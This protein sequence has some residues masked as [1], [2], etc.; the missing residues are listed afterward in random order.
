VSFE[1][2]YDILTALSKIAYVTD[3]EIDPHL[4]AKKIEPS[5][6]GFSINFE[7]VSFSYP[8]QQLLIFD[9]LSFEI[10][11]G[12]RI[13]FD[14]QNGSGKS[15]LIRII[16]G[17]YQAKGRI[18]YDGTA[19]GL[20]DPEDFWSYTGDA[21]NH[22]LIFEGTIEENITLGRSQV[23]EKRLNEVLKLVGI[24]D[25]LDQVPLGLDFVLD[26]EGKRIPEGVRQKIILARAIVHKPRLL[27]LENSLEHLLG[28]EKNRLIDYLTNGSN[29]WTL[30]VVSND[31]YWNKKV[32]RIGTVSTAS[33]S[34]KNN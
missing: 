23:N 6:V 10:K 13:L 14:G 18:S 15:T 26:P 11:A 16:A 32:D 12:E 4:D 28:E 17:L 20:F 7:D 19:Y 31:E 21:L 33:I 30:I 2:I 27:I 22:E 9:H 29:P 24:G 3:L 34:W 25:F 8:N 5:E 1:T